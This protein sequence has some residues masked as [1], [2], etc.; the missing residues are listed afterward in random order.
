MKSGYNILLNNAFIIETKIKNLSN[1]QDT[2]KAKNTYL[3]SRISIDVSMLIRI[4]RDIF[5]W[6]DSQAQGAGSVKVDLL[7]LIKQINEF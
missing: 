2:S 1:R 5:V 4:K 7:T 3:T 6:K